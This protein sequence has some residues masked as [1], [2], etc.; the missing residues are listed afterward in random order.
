[1]CLVYFNAILSIM[2]GRNGSKINQLLKAW[3]RG[4]VAVQSWLSKRG[5]YRQLVEAYHNTAWLNRVGRGAFARADDKV[6]W[7]GG[8]YAIQEQMGLAI[9]AGAKTALEMQGYAHFLKLGKGA[10]VSLF[11]SPDEKLPA[12]F[13]KHDWDVKLHYTATKLF[14]HET[15]LGLTKKEEGSYS[16]TISS[17]ERAVME[18]LHLVPQEESL[19]EAILLMEGLT[20]LRPRLV[21]TL[22]E[23]CRSVKV[24]RLFMCLGE[25]CNHPWVNKLDLSKV[26]FGRGKRMIVKGGHFDPKYKITLPKTH[27]REEGVKRKR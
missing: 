20:T 21:Q 9:H 13:K 17:P 12:W 27:F 7:T 19:E 14:P 18:I 15:N 4:T 8:L 25:D 16:V 24:K 5:V 1:M 3:P 23:Q 26:S 22:M 2:N 11:G 6:E 10:R